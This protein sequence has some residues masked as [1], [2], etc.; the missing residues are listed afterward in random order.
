MIPIFEPDFHRVPALDERQ[1]VGE[2]PAVVHQIAEVRPAV[3]PDRVVGNI[4]GEVDLRRPGGVVEN[5][6]VAGA[7]QEL[8]PAHAGRQRIAAH[9]PAVVRDRAVVQQIVAND[10]V[11][12][13]VGVVRGNPL[14]EAV[15][16]IGR[17]L[18]RLRF[19]IEFRRAPCHLAAVAD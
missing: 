14:V 8:R 10:P 13:L 18:L 16:I 19:A 2:L 9:V 7:P 6:A 3:Q 4:A 1:V 15:A 12:L 5:T 11:E 17:V